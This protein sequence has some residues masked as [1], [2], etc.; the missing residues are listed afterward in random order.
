M[1]EV[2]HI[3]QLLVRETKDG[4]RATRR[5]MSTGS[6]RYDLQPDIGAGT[7][8]RKGRRGYIRVR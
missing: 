6:K 7:G 2:D 8:L 4:E 1:F 5:R 3:G